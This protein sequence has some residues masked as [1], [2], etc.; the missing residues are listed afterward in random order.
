[1][2]LKVCNSIYFCAVRGNKVNS[3][4]LMYSKYVVSMTVKKK[5]LE[6]AEILSAAL[7]E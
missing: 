5:T 3:F 2:T 4:H 1:M 6:P 7:N